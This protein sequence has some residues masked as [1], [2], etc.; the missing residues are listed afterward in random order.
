MQLKMI[1]I[2][3][4]GWLHNFIGTNASLAMNNEQTLHVLIAI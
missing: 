2:G 4:F 3:L 1:L